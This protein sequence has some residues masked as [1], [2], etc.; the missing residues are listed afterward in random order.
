MES[1]E[2]HPYRDDSSQD[3]ERV[4]LP[5]ASEHAERRTRALSFG[6]VAEDYDRYRPLPPRVALD[7][8]LPERVSCAVD[9]AAGTG[10][11]S[12]RLLG[13]AEEVIAVEPDERMAAVL[14]RRLPTVRLLVGRAESLPLP[15]TGVDAV[16]VSSAWH[17]LDVE[18][19][20]AE[21]ARVLRPAGLLGILWTS[22][23]R[24]SAHGAAL[25]ESAPDLV[26][27][28]SDRGERHRPEDICLPVGAPF[29]RPEI[30]RLQASWRVSPKRLAEVIGTYSSVI[31]LP[32][33]ER[34][35]LLAQVRISVAADAAF[36]GR[37][38]VTVPLSCRC[39][40][41]RRL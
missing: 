28:W 26:P 5:S 27:S 40:K 34:E 25:W 35:R 11:L 39:W 18:A 41:A 9:L 12:R 33:P 16:L 30:T 7:W 31:T 8:L 19:A 15:D 29:A 1:G 20:V 36:V 38:R 10:A 24:Q 13:R 4:S 14:A 37:R 32:A 6:T 22:L 23:D 21:I 2:M 17:W 3:S